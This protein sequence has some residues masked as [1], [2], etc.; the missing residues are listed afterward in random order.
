MKLRV[1][2]A[3]INP[4][5]GDIAG[6][7]EK[8]KSFISLA[9]KNQVDLA[10]FP[11]LS[12]IGYPPMDLLEQEHFIESNLSAAETLTKQAPKMGVIIGFVKK[13]TQQPGMPLLNCAGLLYNGKIIFTVAQTGWELV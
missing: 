2:I 8:I 6:N 12:V 10:I 5:V 1:G 13:N 3:Q 7:L 11:E 9:K 4:T